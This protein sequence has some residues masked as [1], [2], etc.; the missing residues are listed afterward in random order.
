MQLHF[1]CRLRTADMAARGER[2]IILVVASL[3]TS[4]RL[5]CGFSK[6][7]DAAFVTTQVA[8]LTD[9]Y[10][11]VPNGTTEL[12]VEIGCISKVKIRRF[13]SDTTTRGASCFRSR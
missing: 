6:T 10:L 1:L 12:L 5:V 7:S 2:R 3:A 11:R 8:S 9:G 13:S 4:L